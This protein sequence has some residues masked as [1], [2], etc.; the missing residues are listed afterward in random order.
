KT[1]NLQTVQFW[2]S[3]EIPKTAAVVHARL[4]MTADDEYSLFLDGREV[5]RGAEWHELFD[6]NLTP[7]MSPG[8]HI[9][10]V[11]AMNSFSLAGMLFGMRVDL[12]DGRAVEVKSDES[13]RIVPAGVRGWEKATKAAAAW[14]KATVVAPLGGGP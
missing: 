6:Y 3:F 13:W 7:L 4:R 12:A 8:R 2:K 10:A 1:L 14:P 9:L 5:G 11:N